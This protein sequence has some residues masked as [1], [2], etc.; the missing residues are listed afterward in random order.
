MALD[1]MSALSCAT[2]VIQFVDFGTKLLSKS[3]EI[4]QSTDG[5]LEE[6]AE[7]AAISTRLSELS[8][9]LSSSLSVD[10]NIRSLSAAEEALQ[11]AT[12]RCRTV[13]DDFAGA[14]D[15]L[16]VSGGNRKWKSFYQAVKNIWNK[17]EVEQKLALLDR[18]QQDVVIHLLI[19]IKCFSQTPELPQLLTCS[20]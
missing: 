14:V 20:A 15:K 8:R 3:R 18:L 1:P 16:R 2:A 7:Q 17:E 10:S 9:R 19:C 5:I 11:D 6:Q 4:Y 12:I 13:A